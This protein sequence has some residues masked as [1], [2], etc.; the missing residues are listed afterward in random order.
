MGGEILYV[1]LKHTLTQMVNLLLLNKQ[2]HH[3]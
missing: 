3:V 1:P 2:V